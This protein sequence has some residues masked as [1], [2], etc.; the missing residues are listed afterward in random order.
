MEHLINK[1]GAAA[2]QKF[3]Q[4][5]NPLDT[6]GAKVGINF[7]KN[8]MFYNTINSHRLMEWCNSKHPEKADSLMEELF[9]AYFEEGKN[10]SDVEE[11]SIIAQ[12]INDIN[13]DEVRQVLSSDALLTEVLQADQAA[14]SVYRV[15][16]VPFFIIE[17]NNGSQPVAFSGAQVSSL[18]FFSVLLFCC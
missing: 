5:G 11:L 12:K 6:A 14:K 9:H 2:V 18:I 15:R 13:P 17:N 8:R 16:G 10:I 1:Y 7:K 4:P 3:Q